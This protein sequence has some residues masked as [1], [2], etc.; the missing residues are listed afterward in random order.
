MSSQALRK[1]EKFTLKINDLELEKSYLERKYP[2]IN[3][4]SR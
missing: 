2:E 1:L 4:L 3:K